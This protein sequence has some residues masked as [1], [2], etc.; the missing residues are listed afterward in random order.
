MRI[1]ITSRGHSLSD[2]LHD[3]IETKV[4][5]LGKYAHND[6]E[7]HVVMER[8]A[9]G[10]IVEITFHGLHKVMH[11]REIGDNVRACI[12]KAVSKVEA[13][14]RKRKDKLTDRRT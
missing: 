4:D 3:Y 14:I 10:Q 1:D 12:D 7:A 13:Q 8:G 6:C 11:G 2:H 5:K 9:A